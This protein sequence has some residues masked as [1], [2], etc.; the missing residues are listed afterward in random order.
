MAGGSYGLNVIDGEVQ[1][2]SP[3]GISKYDPDQAG[4]CPLKGRLHYVEKL[5]EPFTG[6]NQIGVTTHKELEHHLKTGEMS[7]GMIAL[8]AKQYI[9]QKRDHLLIE[10]KIEPGALTVAGIRTVGEIDVLDP[11]WRE[12]QI[13]TVDEY[14]DLVD[15][16]S[17]V[18]VLDWKTTSDVAK[19][20]K[21]AD[22]LMDTVQMPLYGMYALARDPKADFVRLSHVYMQT[23]G[24]PRSSKETIRVPREE[25]NKRWTAIEAFARKIKDFVKESD[26]SKIPKNRNACKAWGRECMHKHTFCAQSAPQSIDDIFGITKA[27]QLK[28][29]DTKMDLEKE[30]ADLEAGAASAGV[31]GASAPALSAEAQ[32]F[33]ADWE[34][35]LAC[36]KGFPPLT[37]EAAAVYQVATG[38]PV[39]GEALAG[40]GDYGT[41]SPLSVEIVAKLAANLRAK[42]EV[43]PKPAEAPK[44]EVKLPSVTVEIEPEVVKADPTDAELSTM[45]APTKAGEL[46]SDELVEAW[47]EP[48]DVAACREMVKDPKWTGQKISKPELSVVVRHLLENTQGTQ[49]DTTDLE[50]AAFDRGVVEGKA[51][52]SPGGIVGASAEG[53]TLYIDAVPSVPFDRVDAYARKLCSL[54]EEQCGAKDIRSSKHEQLDF[55]KWRGT[56]AAC[57]R[58]MPIEDGVYMIDT[59][60]N[61]INEVIAATLIEGAATY[62]RGIQ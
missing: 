43:K 15:E 16:F 21:P 54:L 57:V 20:S 62:V 45:A 3:S 23:R 46:T 31:L 37:K 19:W 52:M 11:G 4:G 24:A 47:T 34:D 48:A 1:Y 40:E 27:T 49:A 55:G 14:G 7:L 18:E 38:Q 13:T 5:K 50:M 35:I 17:T 2:L 59:R 53:L 42:G 39:T 30:L 33:K 56:L 60:G 6:A 12:G 10:H 28:K 25:I 29:G 51:S 26:V 44:P 8:T 58:A 61:E 41:L 22:K 36:E 32:A 9:P